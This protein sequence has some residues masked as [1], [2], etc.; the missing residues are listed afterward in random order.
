[1][2]FKAADGPGQGPG[3]LLRPTLCPQ[4]GSAC[5]GISRLQNRCPLGKCLSKAL[6]VAAHRH[7]M[8]PAACPASLA[9][10]IA[11]HGAPGTALPSRTVLRAG[12][13][14]MSLFFPTPGSAWERRGARKPRGAREGRECLSG[15]GRGGSAGT[16]ASACG[17]PNAA[18]GPARPQFSPGT[19]GE[20]PRP[21]SPTSRCLGRPPPSRFPPPGLLPPPPPQTHQTDAF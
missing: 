13:E 19:L 1:M 4:E 11:L 16:L 6:G 10:P 5:W 21:L 9:V 12:E 2:V 8:L 15:P 18:C 14:L 20:L 3:A 7:A 17:S